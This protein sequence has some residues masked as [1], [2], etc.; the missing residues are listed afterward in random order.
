[1]DDHKENRKEHS[2][3]PHKPE[4]NESGYVTSPNTD[5]R[6]NSTSTSEASPAAKPFQDTP[7]CKHRYLWC[8]PE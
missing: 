6:P 4:E 3:L 5:A 8:K 7:L 2:S 1:M